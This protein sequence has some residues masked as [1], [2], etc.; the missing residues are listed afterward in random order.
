V[1]TEERLSNLS[2]EN[3][4]LVQEARNQN[5]II[6]DLESHLIQSN[7]K[8]MDSGKE[9]EQLRE[10]MQTVVSLNETLEREN[11]EFK[12][13]MTQLEE[14]LKGVHEENSIMHEEMNKLRTFVGILEKKANIFFPNHTVVAEWK[15]EKPT[16]S[17]KPSNSEEPKIQSWFYNN[18]KKET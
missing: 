14:D 1:K 16:T 13:K 18:V 7:R 6:A 17:D 4:E 10:G 15:D 3:L 12:K 2:E 11:M 5:G 9:N 8:V